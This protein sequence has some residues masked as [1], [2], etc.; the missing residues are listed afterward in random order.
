MNVRPV[1]KLTRAELR[2]VYR[3]IYLDSLALLRAGLPDVADIDL[4]RWAAFDARRQMKFWA[5]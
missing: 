1:P 2:G 3:R 4:R 5:A